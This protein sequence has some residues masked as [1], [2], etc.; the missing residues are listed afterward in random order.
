MA[1]LIS[2]IKDRYKKW[3]EGSKERERKQLDKIQ[4]KRAKEALQH[5]HRMERDRRKLEVEEQLTLIKEA[6]L[7]KKKAEAS[8]KSLSSGSVF[9][10][11]FSSTPSKTKTKRRTPTRSTPVR[12]TPA[13]RRYYEYE[14]EPRIQLAT[15][16][17]SATPKKK[18][19]KKK[20]KKK[21]EWIWD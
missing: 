5:I 21:K 7:K 3:E 15:S 12:R 2:N 20:A 16:R 17:I 10:R 6:E 11:F 19:A 9:D 4:G 18:P 8:A 1:N 14:E 13:K